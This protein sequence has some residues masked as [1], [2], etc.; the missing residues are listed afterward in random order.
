MRTNRKYSRAFTLVE[1]LV[2]VSIIAM[3]LAVI[4]PALGMARSQAKR[5]VCSSNLNQLGLAFSMYLNDYGRKVFP[6]AQYGK[7]D[8][9]QFGIFWYYGFEPASSSTLPEGSR[10]L[11]RK[12]AKLYPYIKQYD[13]VEICPAFPY[14][15]GQYKP[16]YNTKWM[17]YGINCKLSADLREPDRK[18]VNFDKYTGTVSNVL[19][20]TDS[21]Q[22]N[23]FQSPA[24]PANPM[25]EEWHYVEPLGA[26]FVH[27][28]HNLRANILFG[29][30]HISSAKSEEGS[31]DRKLPQLNIGRFGK[32]IQF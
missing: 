22:V 2:V 32:E 12:Y 8:G 18:V 15:S 13:S 4:L 26:S 23:T 24:S 10:P 1:L 28:R 19:I 16:K 30:G 29:D 27:F 3:L 9:G 11:F 31:F 20:F 14:G 17:T 25:F 21:A 7:D 5:V 6:L